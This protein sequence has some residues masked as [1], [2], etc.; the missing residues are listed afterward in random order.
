MKLQTFKFFLS[1]SCL[2]L[3]QTLAKPKPQNVPSIFPV[4]DMSF[5]GLQQIISAN[6]G[7]LGGFGTIEQQMNGAA[8]ELGRTASSEDNT[9][10]TAEETQV[11]YNSQGSGAL[12]MAVPPPKNTKRD[13]NLRNSGSAIHEVPILSPTEA[14]AEAEKNHVMILSSD[15]M[16]VSNCLLKN[17]HADNPIRINAFNLFKQVA[18]GKWFVI[19]GY[20]C[21]SDYQ[22]WKKNI[23]ELLKRKGEQYG[24]GV[25]GRCVSRLVR[26]KAEGLRAK[27]RRRRRDLEPNTKI[28]IANQ[29]EEVRS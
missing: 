28:E 18:A 19:F 13:P 22:C 23:Q 4:P 17:R 8:G 1:S 21:A 7:K 3:T 16:Y 11:V 24:G 29:N 9:A 26:E 15:W 27:K 5:V 6:D 12:A 10:S 14:L 20:V 2:L 25:V